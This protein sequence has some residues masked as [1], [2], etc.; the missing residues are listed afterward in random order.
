MGKSCRENQPHLPHR[1]AQDLDKA[2][3]GLPGKAGRKEGDVGKSAWKT[4]AR[5]YS[6][7]QWQLW[8]PHLGMCVLDVRV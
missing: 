5:P 8:E 7:S 1:Q 6:L 3:R 4:C 2:E